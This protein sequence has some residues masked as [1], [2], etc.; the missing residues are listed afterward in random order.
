MSLCNLFNNGCTEAF[1][2]SGGSN[3]PVTEAEESS[4]Q[5]LMAAFYTSLKPVTLELPE[6]SVAGKNVA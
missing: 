4:S 6:T 1:L 2:T 3:E 5:S